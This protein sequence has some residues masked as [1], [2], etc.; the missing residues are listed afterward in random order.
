[1]KTHEVPQDSQRLKRGDTTYVNYAV[2]EKGNFVQ[3]WSK[4]WDVQDTAMNNLEKMF[5]DL[6]QEA[7]EKIKK[8]EASPLEYFMNHFQ[9]D[10]PLFAAQ[11]GVSRRK[12]K[13]HF[14]PDV[15]KKL[16]DKTLQEY[17][18]FFQIDVDTIKNFKR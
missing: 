13:K 1:M 14:K 16:D 8:N 3:V 4:G 5:H 17:A 18:N 12:I 6:E 9:L 2:D 7:L 15:F 10:L 11:M